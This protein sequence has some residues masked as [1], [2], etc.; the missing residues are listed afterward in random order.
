MKQTLRKQI[1]QWAEENEPDRAVECAVKIWNFIHSE[2]R[3][4]IYRK[5]WLEKGFA[6]IW[7]RI[8]QNEQ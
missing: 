3:T 4:G 7:E 6:A 5:A 1:R 8:K 2:N